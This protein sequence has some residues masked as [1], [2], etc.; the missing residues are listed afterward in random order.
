MLKY[1][2]LPIILATTLLA[3]VYDIRTQSL[4]GRISIEAG[5][6]LILHPNHP[7]V[8]NTPRHIKVT[9]CSTTQ[10]RTKHIKLLKHKYRTH[11][12]TIEEIK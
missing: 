7:L 11:G 5:D 10:C 4:W 6:T 3:T 8:G 12:I 2:V 9:I 1:L